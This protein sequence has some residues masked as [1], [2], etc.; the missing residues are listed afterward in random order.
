MGRNKENGL[1]TPIQT[2][3]GRK[4]IS[5]MATEVKKKS[6]FSSQQIDLKQLLE[7]QLYLANRILYPGSGKEFPSLEMVRV[8]IFI[9]VFFP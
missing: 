1:R 9:G 5:L 3:I 7:H 8:Y 2:L 4:E 6:P